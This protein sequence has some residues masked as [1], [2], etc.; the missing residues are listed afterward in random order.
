MIFNLIFPFINCHFKYL[1]ASILTQVWYESITHL[2]QRYLIFTCDKQSSV[3]KR[4]TLPI[5]NRRLFALQS[6]WE[7]LTG[8][9]RDWHLPVILPV[10]PEM[11]ERVIC[12]G[13]QKMPLQIWNQFAFPPS[14]DNTALSEED[15]DPPSI[16]MLRERF[17]EGRGIKLKDWCY[18][19]QMIA[20]WAV[21][22]CVCVCGYWTR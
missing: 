22:L 4:E 15:L 1:C 21:C 16:M 11:T 12:S 17:A 8:G 3:R 6:L 19:F 10:G 20:L 14:P 18:M 7:T 13:P 9:D 5:S 2:R